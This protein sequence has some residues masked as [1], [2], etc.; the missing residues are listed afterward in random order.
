MALKDK[1]ARRAYHRDYMRKRFQT[2]PSY[3]EKH[4][5]RIRRNDKRRRDEIKSLVEN[6]KSRGCAICGESEP[7][8]LSAHHID[9]SEKEFSISD[10][11]RGKLGKSRILDELDKCVCLCENCH[12]KVHAGVIKLPAGIKE[13]SVRAGELVDTLA[14]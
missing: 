9:S 3:R 10:G 1:E 2:D 7:C 14:S 6:W 13:N 8:C 12:R 5:E 4:L 11:V